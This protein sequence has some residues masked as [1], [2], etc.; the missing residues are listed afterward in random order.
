MSVRVNTLL[1]MLN[2]NIIY[3]AIMK[4]ERMLVV[5]F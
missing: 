4:Q 1:D 3:L 5:I 2:M